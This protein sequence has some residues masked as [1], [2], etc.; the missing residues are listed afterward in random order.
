MNIIKIEL[1]HVTDEKN[2]LKNTTIHISSTADI[3]M[4]HHLRNNAISEN[5]AQNIEI[6][7]V[8]RCF[9]FVFTTL[10]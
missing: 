6:A 3:V 5:P 9:Y 7:P 2:N 4:L 8:K 10:K 1:I